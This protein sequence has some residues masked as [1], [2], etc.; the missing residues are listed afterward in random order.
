MLFIIIA[1]ANTLISIINEIRAKKIIDK[2]RLIAEQK[3]T[4][5]REGKAYQLSP[6]DVVKG[7]IIVYGLGDQVL[8]D[9]EVTSGSIEVNE[10]FITGE[11]NNIT[12]HPGDKLIS[13]SFV[14]S[15][16]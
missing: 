10:S 8:F 3:P 6:E 7:D 14:V 9:S 1:L 11:S 12:K 16:T 13:G 4:V 15:G 5:I 2:M